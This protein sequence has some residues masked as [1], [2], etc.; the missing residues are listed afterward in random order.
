MATVTAEIKEVK[1]EDGQLV[2]YCHTGNGPAFSA[3][4]PQVGGDWHPIAGDMVTAINS[5]AEYHIVAVFIRDS[6]TAA[7]EHLIFARDSMGNIKASVHLK[8]DGVAY[9]GSGTDFV[10]MAAK[11]DQLWMKLWGVFNGW[12]PVYEAALKT[13]F[14]AAFPSAPQTVGSTNLKAE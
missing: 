8:A 13:A 10:A 6:E 12:A 9:V 4:V 11:V 2:A 14:L 5:G 1:R 7:G 3:I